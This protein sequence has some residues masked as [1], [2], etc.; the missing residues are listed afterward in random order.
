MRVDGSVARNETRVRRCRQT[1]QRHDFGVDEPMMWA[2]DAQFS[3]EVA[4]ERA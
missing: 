2:D 3:T 4:D 1:L